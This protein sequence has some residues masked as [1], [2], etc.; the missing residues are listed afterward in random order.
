MFI[1]YNE[2]ADSTAKKMVVASLVAHEVVHQW[3][4]NLVTPSW[5]SHLWLK[6]GFAM[7]FQSYIIDKVR[8]YSNLLY[9]NQSGNK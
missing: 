9:I 4:G 7:F 2:R 6:E 8:S 3:F 5:W 1:S